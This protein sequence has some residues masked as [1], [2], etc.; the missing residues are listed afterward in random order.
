MS[1]G[2]SLLCYVFFW[3]CEFYSKPIKNNLGQKITL[4]KRSNGLHNLVKKL[5][6][7]FQLAFT[8]LES[9]MDTL[10][11][12]IC[13]K[14]VKYAWK[15]RWELC[16][17]LTIK[18]LCEWCCSA[19]FILSSDAYLKTQLIVYDGTFF[20]KIVNSQ[21]LKLPWTLKR[22]QAFLFLTLNK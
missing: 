1:S 21:K 20:V 7:V 16:S 14:Y 2:G 3:K 18:A 11:C 22:F 4:E 15:P 5:F 13:V 19:V 10:V 9:T 8:C 6:P 17:K 12:K